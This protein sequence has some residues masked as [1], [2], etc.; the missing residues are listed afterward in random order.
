MNKESCHDHHEHDHDHEHGHHHNHHLIPRTEKKGILLVG[1]GTTHE[2][3]FALYDKVGE[4]VAE[5][6]PDMEIRW[7]FTSDK[8]RRKMETR[9]RRILSVAQ[10]LDAMRD[11]SFTHVAVQSLHTI[12]GVE[13]NWTKN[14]A[15]SF[16]HWRKGFLQVETGH[17]LLYDIQDLENAAKALASYIPSERKPDEAV[18]LVGHGTYHTGQVYYMSLMGQV[19]RNDPN[20]FMGTLLGE[21]G[22]E[23]VAAQLDERG[24][25]KAYLLP[26]MC[27]PGHH[28]KKDM[29]GDGHHSWKT[30]LTDMGV[31]CVPV[32]AGT[33]GH[34][35]FVD[36]WMGHLKKILDRL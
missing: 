35:G 28:V 4:M 27:V 3:A 14:Q 31:E 22:V 24:I 7:A 15:E 32:I 2:D 13:Y 16:V 36:I 29:A 26:F 34:E 8:V 12:P 5:Q 25:R 33:A 18:V 6:W 20:V 17:P 1:F 9:G 21:P 11:E 23:H 10:A 19:L 30:R